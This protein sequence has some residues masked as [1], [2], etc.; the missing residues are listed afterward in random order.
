MKDKVPSSYVGARAAQLS[1]AVRAQT[2]MLKRLLPVFGLLTGGAAYA[3]DQVILVD[4][5]HLQ[6]QTK[7]NAAAEFYS[8]AAAQSLVVDASGY[9]FRIPAEL[10]FKGLNSLQLVLSKQERYSVP[11][12]SDT[13]RQ[14]LSARTLSP[15]SGSKVFQGFRAGQK[16]IVAIGHKDGD[17]FHVVWVGM[18]EVI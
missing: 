9:K 12:S 6:M 16:G 4:D 8:V 11:W 1:S 5:A 13:G 14:T 15:D 2:S 17:D 10:S 7:D 3:A 18:F